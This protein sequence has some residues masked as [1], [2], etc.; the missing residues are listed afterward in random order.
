MMADPVAEWTAEL[1]IR[2]DSAESRRASAWLR[3]SGEARGV[4]EDC[5]TRLDHCMDEALANVIAYGGPGARESDIAICLEVRC[6]AGL[7][8]AAVH[9]SDA[10][11][12]FDPTSAP[13]AVRPGSLAEAQPG[14]LGI[15]MMRS[16]ADRIGYTRSGERNHLTFMVTW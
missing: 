6:D 5:L 7:N 1:A 8:V 2:A 11:V 4:P 16:Y 13:A 14:G 12:A 9:I 15:Q 3:V 10:G